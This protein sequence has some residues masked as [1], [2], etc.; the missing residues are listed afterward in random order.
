VASWILTPSVFLSSCGNR[1][2]FE[3]VMTSIELTFGRKKRV[4]FQFLKI[5]LDWMGGK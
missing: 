5:P 3:V 1:C 4:I 2:R